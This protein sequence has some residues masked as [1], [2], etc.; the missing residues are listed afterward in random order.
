MVDPT[1]W[2]VLGLAVENRAIPRHSDRGD[3]GCLSGKSLELR[4]DIMRRILY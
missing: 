3:F 1:L 2:N 4:P